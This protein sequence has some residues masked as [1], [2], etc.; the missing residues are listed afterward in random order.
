MPEVKTNIYKKKCP[1]ILKLNDYKQLPSETFWKIFP[2]NLDMNTLKTPVNKAKLKKLIEK[3]KKSWTVHEIKIAEKAL[4]DLTNGTTSHFKKIPK[5]TKNCNAKSSV[6]YG[7]MITDEVGHWLKKKYAAG[8]FNKPPFEDICISPLM[9]SKQKTKIRPI[10][11][12]SAPEGNSVNECM[13]ACLFRKL[14]MSSAKKFGQGLHLAGKNAKFAKTDLQDAY[15]LLPCKKEEQ[16]FFGFQWLDKYFVDISTPFGSRA[17]PAN[18]DDFGETLK[19]ITKT[20]TGTKE[21]WIHRQ[22]D[23]I[24]VISPKNSNIAENFSK[25]YKEICTELNVPFAKDCVNH[26]KAFD[27]TTH[28]TVLGIEF[29]SK[30]MK[31]KLPK[32]K[33]DET[34]AAISNFLDKKECSLLELQKLTGKLNDFGQMHTFCK[35]FKFYQNDFLKNFENKTNITKIIS[36]EV[37]NEISIWAKNVQMCKNGMHIPLIINEAPFISEKYISDAAGPEIKHTLTQGFVISEKIDSGMASMGYENQN[38]TSACIHTWPS[39]FF[40]KFS[41]NSAILECIGLIAPFITNPEKVVGKSVLLQVDNTTCVFAWENRVA[42]NNEQLAILIQ[43]LHILESAIPC[44]IYVEHVKRRSNRMAILV[45]NYSRLSTTKEPD[46]I[47]LK[48]IKICKLDG[49]IVDWIENPTIDCNLPQKI[50]KHVKIK[51]QKNYQ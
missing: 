33:H 48:N 36:D 49:P 29:D 26:E 41:R 45:D 51:L 14:E 9:A 34:L 47:A 16:K 43:T 35:G 19:N 12:L 50:A 30:N 1:E 6:F 27:I 38:I 37:K 3:C 32:E 20:L 4:N 42:K 25:K 5:P 13:D 2:K 7:E 40:K 46:I 39:K 44:R 15:K 18:F 11:N 23:D 31:W 21:K 24:P 10:L 8:P 17:A 22:L 28:G